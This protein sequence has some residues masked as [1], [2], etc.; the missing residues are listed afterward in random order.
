MLLAALALL[1]A[2]PTASADPPLE[3]RFAERAAAL[4]IDFVYRH[5]GT[6]EKYMPE[7]MGPGVVLFDADGV[8]LG[9]VPAGSRTRVVEVMG[10]GKHQRR[11]LDMGLVPGAEVVVVRE[12]PLGDP[13][14]Y[15]VKETSI[16]MRR[17]DA[18]TVL[19]D[20]VAHG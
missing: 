18:N 10:S 9:E 12:A 11:M 4:G 20:E 13:V 16:S 15:R 5:F 2:T 3:P 14:E 8:P 7:N 19:V 6:G 1:L 17:A